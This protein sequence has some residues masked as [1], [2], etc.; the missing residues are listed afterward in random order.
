MPLV[1][2]TYLNLQ[3]DCEP[4]QFKN[5]RMQ[6]SSSLSL[7]RSPSSHSRSTLLVPA[8]KL[9]SKH[10]ISLATNRLLS[11]R[12]LPHLGAMSLG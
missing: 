12:H 4:S 1:C 7:G 9:A 11:Y 10:L 6:D 5:V 3:Q 2:I 8:E